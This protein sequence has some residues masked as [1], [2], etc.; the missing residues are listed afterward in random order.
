VTEGRRGRAGSVAAAVGGPD[1]RYRRCMPRPPRLIV[2]G[3]I[4]HVTAR[5]NRRQEIYVDDA[6]FEFFLL[7]LARVAER[8]GWQ[9]HS[10]CLMRNHYHLL[11][12]TPEPNLSAGM[13][14][15]NFLYAQWFNWRHGVDGHLFQGRF[16]SRLV[17]SDPHLLELSRYIVLNPVRA[18][19]CSDPSEWRW[20][21]YRACTGSAPPPR[22]LARQWLLGVFGTTEPAAQEAFAAFVAQAPSPPRAP[23]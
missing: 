18:G 20:S 19:L 5:G 15:L 4:Y 1:G 12:E 23:P 17:T 7:L 8:F 16:Y 22:F 10:Y 3:G 21:S 6:D 13:H 9:V 11:I 2:P 14:R